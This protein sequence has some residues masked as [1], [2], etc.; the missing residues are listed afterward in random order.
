[1]TGKL[2]L[3]TARPGLEARRA[4]RRRTRLQSAKIFDAGGAFICHAAIRDIS[5]TGLRLVLEMDIPMPASFGV[6]IDLTGETLTVRQV[7][8]RQRMIGVDIRSRT[9][10]T[11][12]RHADMSALRNR[13]YAMN[14]NP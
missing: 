8:R 1:M 12:L 10:P 3:S 11:R 6:L 13:Y 9:T 14:P 5:V 7:W 2:H 4:P